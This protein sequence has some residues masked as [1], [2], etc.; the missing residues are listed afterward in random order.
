MEA[1]WAAFHDVVFE[2]TGKSLSV[3]ELE[4]I[5]KSLPYHIKAIAEEWGKSDTVFRDMAYVEL[6]K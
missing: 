6:K 1:G 2:A 4:G 5:Y 3:M